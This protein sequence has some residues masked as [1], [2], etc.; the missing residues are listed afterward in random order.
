M[1]LT[2]KS[3]ACAATVPLQSVL[4]LGNVA[5]MNVPGVQQGNWNWRLANSLFDFILD[6]KLRNLGFRPQGNSL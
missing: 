6:K 5:H 1:V 2:N 3:K 4:G